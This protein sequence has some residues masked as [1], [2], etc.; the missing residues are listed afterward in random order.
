MDPAEWHF[1]LWRVGQRCRWTSAR[2]NCQ[3]AVMN[4]IW[5]GC[6]HRMNLRGKIPKK[7]TRREWVGLKISQNG[8]FTF[9]H[10][11]VATSLFCPNTF[12]CISLSFQSLKILHMLW[13][14]PLR[15]LAQWEIAVGPPKS[16]GRS[17][18]YRSP[19]IDNKNVAGR[20]LLG[21]IIVFS[22]A[23]GKEIWIPAR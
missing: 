4:W 6:L 23:V 21:H 7:R 3:D 2:Q 5:I 20:V 14:S 13:S 9:H 8:V 12:F 19:R 16:V 15:L 18:G 10:E 11:S 22:S 1:C 17:P